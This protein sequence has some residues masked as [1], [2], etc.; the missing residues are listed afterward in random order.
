MPCTGCF[1]PVEQSPDYGGKA[2]SFVASI[3][4][5]EDPVEAQRV[6]AKVADP[7]GIF[8]RYSL[9]TSKLGRKKPRRRT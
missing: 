1:G 7:T 5:L 9:P 3:V 8:Y 2:L 6:L 4:N